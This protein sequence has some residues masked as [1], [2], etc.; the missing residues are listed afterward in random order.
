MAARYGLWAACTFFMAF[1][2]IIRLSV[3]VLREEIIVRYGIDT[4]EFGSLAGFFY[5]GYA[6]LQIPIGIMLDKY[7]VK[8]VSI[9]WILITAIGT[10][11]FAYCDNWNCI[12]FGRFLIG[13]GSAVAFLSAAK[14]ITSCFPKENHNFMLGLTFTFGL[15][16]AIVGSIPMQKLFNYFGYKE[17]FQILSITTVIIAFIIF[18]INDKDILL[19]EEVTS[20]TDAE[21]SIMD[22]VRLLFN[23]YILTIGVCGGL[24]VGPLEGFADV[25]AMPFFE[26]VYSLSKEA[27]LFLGATCV[28]IGMCIGGPLLGIIADKFPYPTFL[29][30]STGILTTAIFIILFKFNVQFIGLIGLMV[31]LGILCC[32]QVIVFSMASSRVNAKYSGL[33]IAIINCLNM[34]FGH[35]FHKAISRIIQLNW[36]NT[37]NEAGAPLYSIEALTYGLYVIPAASL[38]G[39][40]GFIVIK[41]FSS[42]EDVK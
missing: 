35:F 21:V 3:G 30:S 40:L 29:V 24:L 5:L 12:L 27:S 1:Q 37:L 28:F 13:A 9:F 33:A 20:D 10:L 18:I 19:K 16:G 41:F 11:F 39:T 14:V 32:Y 23:P 7:R 22:A 6:G 25:W 4:L 34:S 8:F 2:F 15:L 42:K 26:K 31:F 17:T 38:I 36:D